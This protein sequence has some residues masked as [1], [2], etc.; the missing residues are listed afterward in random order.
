MILDTG[1]LA[2]YSGGDRELEAQILSSFLANALAYLDA[3][4]VASGT[5]SWPA[6]VHK[7]KGAARA[8]GAEHLANLAEAAEILTDPSEQNSQLIALRSALVHVS[9]FVKAEYE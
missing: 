6:C 3:I 9:E 2:D 1:Q 5:D 7:L 4:D 8:V